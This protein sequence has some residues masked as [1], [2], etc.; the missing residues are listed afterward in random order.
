M[1]FFL[2]FGC[3]CLRNHLFLVCNMEI[4]HFSVFYGQKH[5]FL[6]PPYCFNIE[7]FNIYDKFSQKYRMPYRHIQKHVAGPLVLWFGNGFHHF[8]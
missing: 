3:D 1:F 5:Y 6:T 4:A 7:V 2:D 8:K